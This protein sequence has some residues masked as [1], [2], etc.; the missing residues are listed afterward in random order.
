[1]FF[2]HIYVSFLFL[3]VCHVVPIAAGFQRGILETSTEEATSKKKRDEG[4]NKNASETKKRSELQ[5]VKTSGG[6]KA[7]IKKD[8][9]TL[10]S[11]CVTSSRTL[12]A[13]MMSP[14]R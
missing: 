6:N 4:E 14:C 8:E 9:K 7:I 10:V 13:V 1:M 12:V 5:K 2:F 11:V 3:S